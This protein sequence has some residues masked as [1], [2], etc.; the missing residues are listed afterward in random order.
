MGCTPS[1][2]IK[3]SKSQPSIPRALSLPASSAVHH[4]SLRRGDPS[5]FVSLTSST[6]PYSSLPLHP[7][8]NGPDPSPKSTDSP[9]VI[10]IGDLMSGIDDDDD[11]GGAGDR[12]PFQRSKTF[13][14]V[15]DPPKPLWKHLSEETLLADLD[16]SVSSAFHLLRH[17]RLCK[18]SPPPPSPPPAKK[19]EKVVIYFT[20]LRG[21]R[22][23]YDDCCAVRNIFK[24]LRVA[25]DERDVSMDSSFR[26]EL[27]GL[28]GAKS[29][30]SL[31]QVFVGGRHV[32]GAEEV[33]ELHETGEL[34]RL[35][36]GVPRRDPGI[37]CEGCGD[38]RFVPCPG[39]NGSM[40]VFAEEEG[41]M[42]RCGECNEYGLIRCPGCFS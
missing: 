23:T 6:I 31:P 39:C 4:P 7:Q 15:S 32:G 8:S 12:L 38:V 34:A 21:V 33:R 35:V 26:K 29:L 27:Q 13:N 41:E 11:S 17:R 30:I 5:H 37:A 20:S 28:V 2:P 22:R 40:K 24:G 9:T 42:R 1:R 36:E 16:P 19:D 14:T 18:V 3:S 25:A 10:D